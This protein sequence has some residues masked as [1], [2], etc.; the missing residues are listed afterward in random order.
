MKA[1]RKTSKIKSSAQVSLIFG[2]CWNRVI[3]TNA[4]KYKKILRLVKILYIF[5]INDVCGF[6]QVL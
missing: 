1:Q 2:L 4:K 5:K 6:L 3:E